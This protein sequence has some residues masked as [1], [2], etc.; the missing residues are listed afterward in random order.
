VYYT[1]N[2]STVLR[3]VRKQNPGQHTTLDLFYQSEELAFSF[4][5]EAFVFG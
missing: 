1:P 3:T 2:E 5:A 4:K